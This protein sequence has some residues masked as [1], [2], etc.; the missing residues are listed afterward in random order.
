[1]TNSSAG[2]SFVEPCVSDSGLSHEYVSLCDWFFKCL[3]WHS[4]KLTLDV[5]DFSSS[6]QRSYSF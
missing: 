2:V 6:L 5:T 4:L 1:M 3:S